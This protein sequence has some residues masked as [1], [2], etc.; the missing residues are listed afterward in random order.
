MN[1]DRS[2]KKITFILPF[3][4]LIFFSVN[5]IAPADSIHL[6]G[7]CDGPL[8]SGFA[9]DKTCTGVDVCNQQFNA[10]THCLYEGDYYFNATSSCNTVSPEDVTTVLSTTVDARSFKKY[11][12]AFNVNWDTNQEACVCY[13]GDTNAWL[14]FANFDVETSG[15]CCE[16]DLNENLTSRDAAVDSTL[17]VLATDLACCNEDDK[18][19]NNS[20]CYNSGSTLG[21]LPDKNYCNAGI[22]QGGDDSPESCA[23]I[24]G[25]GRWAIG[26]DVIGDVCC[27]DNNDVNENYT[28]RDGGIRDTNDVACCDT[29]TDC[30]YENTCYEEGR[31]TLGETVNYCT[32]GLWSEAYNPK[33]DWNGENC[34]FCPSESDCITD[35]TE[36]IDNEIASEC[37]DSGEFRD[38]H[39]C[40]SGE[41]TTR[42]KLVALQLM[43]IANKSSPVDFTLLCDS[44]ENTL[45]YYD[46]IVPGTT[47]VVKDYFGDVNICVL[48]LP[49][50]VIFGAALN[51]KI[52]DGAF[53]NTLTDNAGNPIN[54]D[55]AARCVDCD[56]GQFHK[57]GP[58]LTPTL[59]AYYNNKTR[60]VIYSKT[61]IIHMK[62]ITAWDKFISF[63]KNPFQKIFDLI[64]G[65]F[66]DKGIDRVDYEFIKDTKDF[67][68]IYFDNNQFKSIK[69]I[70]E[71]VNSPKKGEYLAISY[72]MYSGDICSTVNGAY[73]NFNPSVGTLVFCHYD[74]STRTYYVA[75][76]HTAAL[77]LWPDLTSKLR[78]KA[79]PEGE[80]QYCYVR[81]T[82]CN[83]GE[84]AI[85]SLSSHTDAHASVLNQGSFEHRLCCP[86][87][88]DEGSNLDNE[89]VRLSA[90]EDAH[91]SAPNTYLFNQPAYI[92]SIDPLQ[93]VICNPIS[94]P[95]SCFADEICVASLSSLEDSHI[96][97][98]DDPN[99]DVKLCCKTTFELC[100]TAGDEDGD[101][102][103]DCQDS[104]CAGQKGPDGSICCQQDYSCRNSNNDCSSASCDSN[105]NKCVITLEPAGTDVGI[106]AECDGAGDIAYDETQDGDCSINNIPSVDVC[107]F[108]PDNNPYTY[109][110]R[111]GFTSECIAIEQCS[112]PSEG[113]DLITHTCSQTSCPTA[114]CDGDTDCDDS[115]PLTNDY[116]KD[117]CTCAHGTEFCDNG[118]DDDDDGFVDCSDPSCPDGIACGES[119][120][121]DNSECKQ[122]YTTTVSLTIDNFIWDFDGGQ[123]ACMFPYE[124]YGGGAR[125]RIYD[126]SNHVIQSKILGGGMLGNGD[127]VESDLVDLLVGESYRVSLSYYKA[128]IYDTPFYDAYG[129]HIFDDGNAGG[130]NVLN[131]G[132]RYIADEI[133][134]FNFGCN[135]KRHSIFSD[136][137]RYFC[138][139]SVISNEGMDLIKTVNLEDIITENCEA[140]YPIKT[141]NICR[142]EGGCSPSSGG[143]WVRT[144]LGRS[145]NFIAGQQGQVDSGSPH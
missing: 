92:K 116:C 35:S 67:S 11:G 72:S 50:Q 125:M 24:A 120:I 25:A 37:F 94:F 136:Y 27:G 58:R 121:C 62:T 10:S 82:G 98:C 41:W 111:L 77:D 143:I 56:D 16:D 4:L 17:S 69:G 93:D 109:D 74:E 51:E 100:G 52:E 22:W 99:F 43:D 117:D 108:N 21:D 61:D 65:F 134:A 119:Q 123:P 1:E 18:C 59:K 38:D 39:Y 12:P 84:N 102:A 45:N 78:T 81:E 66:E 138:D 8:C 44:Y 96:S 135:P 63:L 110:S 55:E 73:D 113:D 46:Y 131:K 85:L 137:N 79:P 32:D 64:F 89:W 6:W 54:C 104:E 36:I 141:I 47:N 95:G 86:D 23:A 31:H 26:G 13:T 83:A 29:D 112:L 28:Y 80:M 70:T 103:A 53:I 133:R 140:D 118:V 132:S 122:V 57:C 91:V 114:P 76:N 90:A 75:S 15:Q 106:C 48:R 107:T 130:Y 49:E 3:L 126:S 145:Y 68:R 42:T 101:G 40:E 128:R 20:K 71:K 105:N 5:V 19:V 129:I 97:G 2:F 87:S 30:V 7:W 60:S 144:D 9:F 127:L 124:F 33:C 115:D 139:G 88:L 14:D 142:P 34:D